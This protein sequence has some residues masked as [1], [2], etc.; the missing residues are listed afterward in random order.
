MFSK[1]G[2]QYLSFKYSITTT[3]EGYPVGGSFNHEDIYICYAI[4][5]LDLNG[6]TRA[7]AIETCLALLVK[8]QGYLQSCGLSLFPSCLQLV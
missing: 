4:W 3:R 6:H 1:P 2:L 8:Q 7:A 5:C